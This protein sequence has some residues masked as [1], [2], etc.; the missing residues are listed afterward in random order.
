MYSY[1]QLPKIGVKIT[2]VGFVDRGLEKGQIGKWVFGGAKGEEVEFLKNT[3]IP[4]DSDRTRT[5]SGRKNGVWRRNSIPT[6][7][8]LLESNEESFTVSITGLSIRATDEWIKS[9][10]VWNQL[11]GLAGII[12]SRIGGRGNPHTLVQDIFIPK[13][14][15]FNG[16]IPFSKKPEAVDSKGH[17][18]P[19]KFI[20]KKYFDA[21]N[22]VFAF[23]SVLR[24]GGRLPTTLELATMDLPGTNLLTMSPAISIGENFIARKWNGDSWDNCDAGDVSRLKGAFALFKGHAGSV[25][26]PDE[27]GTEPFHFY[28]L[29]PNALGKHLDPSTSYEALWSE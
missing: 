11:I 5:K 25:V 22:W 14:S 17:L 19:I 3:L 27:R 29:F 23:Q 7:I 26:F 15:D 28:I 2:R 4:C 9:L 18:V 6:E 21:D 10:C 24:M 16:F 8:E 1:I 13:L 12:D 20:S